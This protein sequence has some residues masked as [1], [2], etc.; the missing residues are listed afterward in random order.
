[1]GLSCQLRSGR[2]E[3]W[4]GTGSRCQSCSAGWKNLCGLEGSQA[5][6]EK[7]HSGLGSPVAA[8]MRCRL[9]RRTSMREYSPENK[10]KQKKREVSGRPGQGWLEGFPRL[11]GWCS[12]T[13]LSTGCIQ[14]PHTRRFPPAA[15]ACGVAVA[16]RCAC[17]TLR[18]VRELCVAPAPRIQPIQSLLRAR[19]KR[20]GKKKKKIPSSYFLV[21]KDCWEH[22]GTN[23]SIQLRKGMFKKKS[24]SSVQG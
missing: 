5:P 2:S 16:P 7:V 4:M 18:R 15:G 20:K 9:R 23:V 22:I 19:E 12:H 3:T 8:G 14:G 21:Q 1:M 13:C 10:T 6:A 11:P 24:V 17:P